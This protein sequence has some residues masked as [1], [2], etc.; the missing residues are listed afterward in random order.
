MHVIEDYFAPRIMTL[1]QQIYGDTM[2]AT[3]HANYI[4]KNN[5]SL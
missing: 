4:N 2:N 1:C 3:I 5:F